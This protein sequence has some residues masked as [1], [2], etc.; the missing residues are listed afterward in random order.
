MPA[1][2]TAPP[3]VKWPLAGS[4][5]LSKKKYSRWSPSASLAEN[6]DDALRISPRGAEMSDAVTVGARFA[7]TLTW[8]SFGPLKR[9]PSQTFTNR[10]SELAVPAV[11]VGRPQL[12]RRHREGRARRLHHAVDREVPTRG[13][14]AVVVEEVQQVVAVGVVG[15]E[16]LRAVRISPREVEMSDAV[17]VGAW[18]A[19][20]LTWNSFGPL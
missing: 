20:M 2:C 19:G 5:L 10:S 9:L 17:T 13:V 4:A 18:F 16:Q 14:R 3:T 7:G 15:R 6:S 12:R 11:K 8:N 1:A